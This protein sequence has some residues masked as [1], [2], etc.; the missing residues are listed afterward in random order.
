[1]ANFSINKLEDLNNESW[2]AYIKGDNYK[3]Y[4]KFSLFWQEC[5]ILS[6]WIIDTGNF[7]TCNMELIN[8]F[9]HNIKKHPI[10]FRFFKII[11]AV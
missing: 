9:V 8:R 2:N 6:D 1:M 10:L 4:C 3:E 11:F 5:F 7:Q